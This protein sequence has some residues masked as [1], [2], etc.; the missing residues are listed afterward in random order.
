MS[1]EQPTWIKLVRVFVVALVVL[2]A[3]GIDYVNFTGAESSYFLYLLLVAPTVGVVLWMLRSRGDKTD[4][5]DPDIVSPA[6]RV[7]RIQKQSKRRS[8]NERE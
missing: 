8:T 1:E 7:R 6:E 4:S 2:F 3:I 5:D